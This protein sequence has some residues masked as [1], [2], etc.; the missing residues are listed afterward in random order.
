MAPRYSADEM[1]LPQAVERLGAR[2]ALSTCQKVQPLHDG[3]A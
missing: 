2:R 1:L 3:A